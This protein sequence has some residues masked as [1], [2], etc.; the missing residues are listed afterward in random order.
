MLIAAF[1]CCSM[2]KQKRR[3]SGF[4]KQ[5]ALTDSVYKQIQIMTDD[6]RRQIAFAFLRVW[7]DPAT[8]SVMTQT[9][10]QWYCLTLIMSLTAERGCQSE[11]QLFDCIHVQ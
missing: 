8:V 11:V 5:L 6:D 2:E 10:I 1:D 7:A 4:I 3:V 9:F